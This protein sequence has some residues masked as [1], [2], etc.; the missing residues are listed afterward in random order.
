[1]AWAQPSNIAGISRGVLEDGV[2]IR[3]ER[4]RIPC[5]LAIRSR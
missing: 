4:E 3:M 2:L 1:M 5:S